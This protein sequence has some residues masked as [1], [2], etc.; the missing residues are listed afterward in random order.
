[1]SEASNS[2]RKVRE[3]MREQLDHRKKLLDRLTEGQ[4]VRVE[5]DNVDYDA[6]ITRIKPSR[7]LLPDFRVRFDVDGT[8]YWVGGVQIKLPELD[9]E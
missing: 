4:K 9:Q 6:V 5:V 8:L 3:F 7:L 1:M 2:K